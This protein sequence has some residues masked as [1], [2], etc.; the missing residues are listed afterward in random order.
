MDGLFS[1]CKHAGC[2]SKHSFRAGSK[3]IAWQGSNMM[4][5]TLKIN[6]SSSWGSFHPDRAWRLQ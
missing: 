3:I 6:H 2:P 5:Y 4:N 1:F